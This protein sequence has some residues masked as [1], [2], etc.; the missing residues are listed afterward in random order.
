MHFAFL[1]I[2]G[3]L[4]FHS[5]AI[6]IAYERCELLAAFKREDEEEEEEEEEEGGKGVVTFEFDVTLR[7]DG[8]PTPAPTDIPPRCAS[9]AKDEAPRLPAPDCPS[10]E[11]R[12]CC[13][14]AE[15]IGR[16]PRAVN[17]SDDDDDDDAE[18]DTAVGVAGGGIGLGIERGPVERGP[19]A[20]LRKA[21]APV[22]GVAALTGGVREAVSLV[23]PLSGAS[24]LLDPPAAAVAAVAAPEGGRVAE[25]ALPMRLETAPL[26]LRKGLASATGV[27]CG[28]C[29]G[30]AGLGDGGMGW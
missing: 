9:A 14:R 21:T 8:T 18:D 27:P 7:S 17:E 30:C 6:G 26:A 5:S 16:D 19:P 11:L 29:K 24:A 3:S 10:P 12:C 1:F 2:G 20:P 22:V 23:T 13:C 25:P 15:A 28:G 4:T